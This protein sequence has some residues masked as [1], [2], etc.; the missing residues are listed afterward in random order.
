MSLSSVSVGV[1]APADP[2]GEQ[3]AALAWCRDAV[4][5]VERVAP[6]DLA[7]DAAGEFDVLWWHAAEPPADEVVAAAAPG[8][9]AHLRAGGGLFLSLRALEAVAALGV[10]PVPPD[11][12]GIEDHH[13]P[14][15]PLWKA[16]RADHAAFD[17]F[18][19]LRLATLPPGV[20]P[21]AHYDA[22]LP[23]RG[24]VLAATVH[25]EEDWPDRVSTVAWPTGGLV[26]NVQM[27][28][29]QDGDGLAADGQVEDG[30]G[31]AAGPVIGMG[32]GLRFDVGVGSAHAR[33]R[34][35]SNLLSVL[36]GGP[37]TS[38]GG[39]SPL[40]MACFCFSL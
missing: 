37:D 16:T 29:G 24:E 4:G 9:R 30:G 13:E 38:R 28:E 26:A 3:A 36:A 39:A 8:V 15:G 33:A 23:E 11:A 6:A 35:A 31:G 40:S 25:G 7:P 20:H 2:G 17:G 12:T 14:T 1:I 5:A 18:D 34:L 19:D 10:D 21:F 22:V 32:A 27:G